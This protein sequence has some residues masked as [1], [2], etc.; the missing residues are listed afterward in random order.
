MVSTSFGGQAFA[1]GASRIVNEPQTI[2]IARM[3]KTARFFR[4]FFI[5]NI[6]IFLLGLGVHS[7]IPIL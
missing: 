5:R 1:F 4:K 2:T 3:V 7:F 6:S